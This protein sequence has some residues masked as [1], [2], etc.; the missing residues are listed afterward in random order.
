M[1]TY[2][3]RG[4]RPKKRNGAEEGTRHF[5]RNDKLLSALFEHHRHLVPRAIEKRLLPLVV[6]Q[7]VDG[8]VRI[9]RNVTS[10]PP[11]IHLPDKSNWSPLVSPLPP[12]KRATLI[13]NEV[14]HRH[15]ISVERF[16][17]DERLSDVLD[18]RR[19]AYYRI[20]CETP[21]SVAAV[22]RHVGRD[23]STIINAI[24]RFCDKMGLPYPRKADAT[25]HRRIPIQRQP[26]PEMVE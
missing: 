11:V 9:T 17:G 5:L 6:P 12:K 18:A 15:G 4:G 22:G 26:Y 16:L 13:I 3:D 1:G 19:E 24:S 23:H 21:M 14:C 20:L 7:P 2:E 10:L 25:G 8:M